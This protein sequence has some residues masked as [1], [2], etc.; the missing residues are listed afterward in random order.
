[1]IQLMFN[2]PIFSQ[3]WSLG[4]ASHLLVIMAFYSDFA[5]QAKLL[6]TSI[7]QFLFAAIIW[8][9]SL[10]TERPFVPALVIPVPVLL[11]LGGHMPAEDPHGAVGLQLLAAPS[12][13]Y[14]FF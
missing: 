10:P 11:H 13:F 12:L 14:V 4:S 1:M 2:W 8:I 7:S 5:L 3:G 6:W 9:H